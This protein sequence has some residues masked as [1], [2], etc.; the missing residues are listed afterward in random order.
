MKI[1]ISFFLVALLLNLSYQTVTPNQLSIVGPLNK[2]AFGCLAKQGYNWAVIRVYQISTS[3]APGAVDTNAIQTLINAAAVGI[4]TDA[5]MV[6]CRNNDPVSQ[7]EAVFNTI[8]N[9][10]FGFLWIKVIPN[11]TP[12]CLW[13]GHTA[14]DNCNFLESAISRAQIYTPLIGIFT[15][16]NIWKQLFGNSCNIWAT[17]V[18]LFYA[19]YQTNGRVN[20]NLDYTDF[21]TFGGW[22]SAGLKQVG[23]SVTVTSLCGFPTWR[24]FIDQLWSQPGGV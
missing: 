24:A 13:T 11:T 15:T 16:A 4:P 3:P 14:A 2:V 23:G 5:Y 9:N 1:V 19:N 21:K 7:I 12:G 8:D 10:L 6:I 18:P 17:G 22:T 20:S